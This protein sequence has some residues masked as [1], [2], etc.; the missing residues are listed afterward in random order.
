MKRLSFAYAAGSV[1]AFFSTLFAWLFAWLGIP[2]AMGVKFVPEVSSAWLYLR[3]VWG[4]LW[5]L[6]FLAPLLKDAWVLR[7]LLFG[8]L[9]SLVQLVVVFPSM[10]AGMLGLNLGTMTP[11]MVIVC[12]SIWGIVASFWFNKVDK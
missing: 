5:G 12:N 4:G 10:K 2:V 11:V 6:L 3:L 7:G 1:G 8:L 9:P